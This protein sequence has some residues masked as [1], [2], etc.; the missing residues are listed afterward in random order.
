MVFMGPP[1][2]PNGCT[3]G[4][5]VCALIL[6]VEGS[7]PPSSGQAASA[8]RACSF[9]TTVTAAARSPYT[10]RTPAGD[11]ILRTKYP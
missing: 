10:V 3:F 8:A 2:V 11:D 1:S 6:E 4:T 9:S 5:L 7:L